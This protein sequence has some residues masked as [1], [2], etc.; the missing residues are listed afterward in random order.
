MSLH[1]AEIA[2]KDAL[3]TL[4]LKLLTWSLQ[5]GMPNTDKIVKIP[6]G[7]TRLFQSHLDWNLY[8]N[9]QDQLNVRQV[10]HSTP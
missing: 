3:V 6:A 2:N 4:V 10:Q 1:R 5:A 8:S 7:I 9:K